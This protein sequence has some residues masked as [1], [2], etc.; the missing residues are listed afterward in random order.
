MPISGVYQITC[1]PANKSYIGSSVNTYKRWRSGHLSDLRKNKHCNRYL[2]AA[3]NKYG[4]DTF[5]HA[6][7]EECL[8]ATLVIREQHWIDTLRTTDKNFGYN[9]CKKAGSTLGVPQTD[10]CKKA[11]LLAR[12]KTYVVR[13]ANG[14][15]RQITNLVQFCKENNLTSTAMCK[16]A[17]GKKRHHKGWECRRAGV[18]RAAWLKTIQHLPQKRRKKI[19]GKTAWCSKCCRYKPQESFTSDAS[20]ASKLAAYCRSCCKIKLQVQRRKRSVTK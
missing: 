8:P 1:G 5:T 14:A 3:W 15:E 4:E 10:K 2:Q 17:A 13:D 7:I 20:T 19:N 12:A 18:S 16:V 6:V 9:L 11:I